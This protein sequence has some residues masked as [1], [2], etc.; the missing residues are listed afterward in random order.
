MRRSFGRSARRIAALL[1][2]LLVALSVAPGALADCAHGT[3]A[4]KEV[5]GTLKLVEGTVEQA[6]TC[7]QCGATLGTRTA[8]AQLYEGEKFLLSGN[9]MMER[10]ALVMRRASPE[11]FKNL[12]CVRVQVPGE[13]FFALFVVSETIKEE[14]IKDEETFNALSSDLPDSGYGMGVVFEDMDISGISIDGDQRNNSGYMISFGS[15]DENMISHL[16]RALILTCDPSMELADEAEHLDE[17][18]KK[19]R[20][21]VL[22]TGDI[23]YSCH[24]ISYQFIFYGRGVSMSGV[25]GDMESGAE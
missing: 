1:M 14:V 3:T 8:P 25:I 12:K 5:E 20:D 19:L 10:F 15:Q 22:L 16:I 23:W 18:A 21:S 17:L 13:S 11:L 6:E 4:W 7:T 24:G 2:A 9:E